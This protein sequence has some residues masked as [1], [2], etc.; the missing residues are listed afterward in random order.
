MGNISPFITSTG[1]YAS[2][3][4]RLKE[5][6]AQSQA[7]II[8]AGAGLSA[9]AGSDYSGAC[10]KKVFA[11]F[12][13]RYGIRDMYSGCFT[14]FED[15][16]ELW[17]YWSRMVLICRYE[18]P[19]DEVYA[20]LFS[21]VKDKNY[22]VLTTNVDHRFQMAGFDK[23]RLFYTQGDYGLWQCSVP[24]HNKTYDNER[25]VRRMVEE[26]RDMKVPKKLL[27]RCPVCGAPMVENLRSD[28]KFVQDD[29]WYAAAERYKKFLSENSRGRILYLELGVGGNTP[30][31]IKYPFWQYTARNKNATYACINYGECFAP[32]EIAERTIC[33]DADIKQALADCLQAP[34]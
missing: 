3:I 21:L 12:I 22:F 16:A 8:G 23:S 15:E 11:D 17:A 10:F 1:S 28:D 18:W 27:P 2:Q 30:G 19:A 24:C 7:V 25:Q 6:L 13:K 32:R 14:P 29:G 34:Q 26:Q 31:I 9:S 20:A 33:I 4:A 5:C